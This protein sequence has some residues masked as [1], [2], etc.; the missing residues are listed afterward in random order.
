MTSTT[1]PKTGRARPLTAT[2]RALDLTEAAQRNLLLTAVALV[3]AAGLI[4]EITLTRLFSLLF[5]YHYAFLAVSVAVMG[6]GFGAAVARFFPPRRLE[7][8]LTLALL[9]VSASFPLA[10]LSLAW[11][12]ST[13]TTVLH[14]AVT[15]V[16][17]TLIGYFVALV[18]ARFAASGGMLYGADLVGA[19]I[20]VLTVLGLLTLFSAFSV[21]ILLGAITG[22]AALVLA[23]VLN[24]RR[25]QLWAALALA[26]SLGLLALNTFTG[27]ADFSPTR[28]ADYSRDKTMLAVLGD[29]SQAARIALTVWD[30]FARVDVV[31]TNDPTQK[32]VFA[33]GG[34]GSF[35]LR[36]DGDLTKIAALTDSLEF[37]PFTVKPGGRTLILG[38]GAGRDV[39]LALLAGNQPITA[40]EVNPAMVKAVREFNDYTGNIYDR[41]E[42]NLEIGDART[43]VERTTQQYDLI[44][45]NLVYSQA[46]P[47]ASQALVENYIFT[48]EAFRAYLSKLAPGGHLAIVAHNALEGSRAALTALD[49]MESMGAP[50]PDGLNRVALLMQYDEDPTERY[51]ILIVGQQSLTEAELDII[52]AGIQRVPD[53]QALYM[54]VGFDLPFKGLRDGAVTIE[55]FDAQDETYT[56]GPTRD[57]R[58]FFFKLDPGLPEAIRN[59]LAV[60]GGLSLALLLVALWPIA[61]VNSSAEG[62]RWLGLV[63]YVGLI[64]LGFMLIEIP[65][66]QRFQLLLGQ[67]ILAVITVL[68]TLLLAS[69]LS[70]WWSQRW[71]ATSLWTRVLMAALSV[72]AIALVYW[73]ALPA[74]VRAAL[75]WPLAARVLVVTGLTAL[76]A[77]PLGIPFPS[78]LRLASDQPNH[79][80]AALWGMNGVFSVLGSVLATAV[81]MTWGFSYA[82]FAGIAAYGALALV[83]WLA[84]RGA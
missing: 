6:L 72:A 60:A 30:P 23:Y 12:P 3:S 48:S 37:I 66:I 9:A 67:P 46:A 36:F 21:V 53:M 27:L 57:D 52:T 11:L 68:G 61:E 58:P 2:P 8:A 31:E 78:A 65:L 19:A 26:F 79:T 47:P 35:M 32:F 18:F 25:Q 17:F 50:I 69:G 49:A 43:Y 56:L 74:I 1:L 44:Y 73:L 55:E 51:S 75:P 81:A 42:V 76:I 33:D 59:A 63:V 29:P 83:A 54:P 45:L 38:A 77:V 14:V 7:A 41:P 28:L 15:L 62:W 80:L 20:G 71:P 22:L 84:R 16:P 40:L 4:F 24:E 34:A 5:Q 10:A 82:L 64:G 13:A 70:S 39:A